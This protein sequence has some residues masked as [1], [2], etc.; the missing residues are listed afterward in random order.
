[1]YVFNHLRSE[2]PR[3]AGVKDGDERAVR[4]GIH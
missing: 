3:L 2:D 1:M 4:F